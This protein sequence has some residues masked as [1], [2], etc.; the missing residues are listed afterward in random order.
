MLGKVAFSFYLLPIFCCECMF[1]VCTHMCVQVHIHMCAHECGDQ[2]S[3]LGVL[4]C[5]QPYSF[6]RV[7]DCAWTLLIW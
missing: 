4:N 5:S 2:R 7:S 1:C 3:T 6:E